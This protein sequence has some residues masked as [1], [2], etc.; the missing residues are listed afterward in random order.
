MRYALVLGA[1][2]LASSCQAQ[3]TTIVGRWVMDSTRSESATQAVPVT[4]AEITIIET[5]SQF[6][7]KTRQGPDERTVFYNRDG[8]DTDTKFGNASASGHMKWSGNQLVTDTTYN[9][10]AT[11]LAQ[12]ATYS[13]SADGREL[14]VEYGLRVLHGYEDNHQDAVKKDPNYSGGRDVFVRQ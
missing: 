4:T 7:I 5:P 12:T 6:K 1:V 14:T 9:V 11:A 2:I 8:S 13:L 10:R 3:S